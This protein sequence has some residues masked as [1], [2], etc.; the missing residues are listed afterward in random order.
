MGSRCSCDLEK[1][2]LAS[3][4]AKDKKAAREAAKA[5]KTVVMVTDEDMVKFK[6]IMKKHFKKPTDAF[7]GLDKDG[8]TTLSKDEFRTALAEA[9][10]EGTWD[11]E[12]QKFVERSAGAIFDEMDD[13]GDGT[14]TYEE[15]VARLKKKEGKE[16]V[17]ENFPKTPIAARPK[18]DTDFGRQNSLGRQSSC[19]SPYYQS[20]M[21]AA[22]KAEAVDGIKK[23]KALLRKTFKDPLDAFKSLDKDGDTEL[24]M[25]EFREMLA[26]V[27][28]EQ[29]WADDDCAAIINVADVVFVQMDL[30]KDGA[31]SRKEFKRALTKT[32]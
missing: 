7:K 22:D 30:D 24:N 13:D 32:K 14:L 8:D 18:I 6:S 20:E 3:A 5:G 19:G 23:L 26:T 28:T 25:E 17:A 15:F 21:S 16:D 10:E 11:A 31:V 27:G 9:A 4:S 12:T 29:S 2:D 1:K